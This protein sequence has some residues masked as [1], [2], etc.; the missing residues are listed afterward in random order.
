MKNILLISLLIIFLSNCQSNIRK[1][2]IIEDISTHVLQQEWDSCFAQSIQKVKNDRADMLSNFQ[3]EDSIRVKYLDAYL[4][5]LRWTLPHEENR[6][7]QLAQNAIGYLSQILGKFY[8]FDSVI[9]IEII[10]GIPSNFKKIDFRF[11]EQN[12]TH[13][14]TTFYGKENYPNKNRHG[15]L[16]SKDSIY[17]QKNKD[18]GDIS[19]V[20]LSKKYS[21]SIT[22]LPSPSMTW[23]QT[24]F[25]YTAKKGL[26]I[27]YCCSEIGM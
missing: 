20:C 27:V 9:V 16:I 14:F 5:N 26:K 19:P 6:K 24:K 13:T 18:S 2:A 21:V 1:K 11:D 17:Y 8:E 15:V 4:D 23:Q 7:S 10:E 25:I 22:L 3:E 12:Y